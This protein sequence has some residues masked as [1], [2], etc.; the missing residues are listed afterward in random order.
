MIY[1]LTVLGGIVTVKESDESL[2]YI[3]NV[4]D[5]GCRSNVVMRG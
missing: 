2:G 5:I 4:D 3:L 1:A